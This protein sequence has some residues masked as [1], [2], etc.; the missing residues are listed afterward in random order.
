[1]C[2]EHPEA[3]SEAPLFSLARFGPDSIVFHREYGDFLLLIQPEEFR[4]IAER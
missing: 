1:M 4:P 3:R 2:R